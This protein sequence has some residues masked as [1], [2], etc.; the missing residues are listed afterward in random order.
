[1]D[2]EAA[3][4]STGA[5][6]KPSD[7]GIIAAPMP[8]RERTMM[9]LAGYFR[10]Q[11]L[12]LGAASLSVSVTSPLALLTLCCLRL[13][14]S[15]AVVCRGSFHFGVPLI[16]IKQRERTMWQIGHTT[17]QFRLSRNRVAVAAQSQP[18]ALTPHQRREAVRLGIII[19]ENR[20]PRGLAA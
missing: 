19:G 13:R 5:E 9:P 8:G 17:G 12:H 4:L 18:A 6:S 10:R 2:R 16:E 7:R 11:P 14:F 15:F 3:E 20:E 1:M